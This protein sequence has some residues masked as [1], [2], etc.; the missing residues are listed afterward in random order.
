MLQHLQESVAF[1]AA[2]WHQH[3]V[4]AGEKFSSQHDDEEKANREK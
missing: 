4:I 1:F 3:R 2:S